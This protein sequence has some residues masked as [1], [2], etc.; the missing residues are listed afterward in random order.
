MSAPRTALF[1][2]LLVSLAL[3]TVATFEVLERVQAEPSD[4]SV[5]AQQEGVR[6]VAAIRGSPNPGDSDGDGFTD[7]VESGTPLCGNGLNEDDFDDA[8]ADDGCPGGPPQAGSFSEGQFTLGTNSL[9]NCQAGRPLGNIPST[10]WPL[11]IHGGDLILDSRNLIDIADLGALLAP[12]R[13]LDTSPG[14]ANYDRRYDLIPGPDPIVAG[15]WIDITDFGAFLAG[16]E[17]FPP[18]FGIGVR[19]LD[20]PAC[21]P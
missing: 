6:V 21:T 19:A 2:A 4:E 17:A 10:D 14:D 8:V 18:M 3:L 20:G 9:S 11:D 5:V 15:E 1:L 7:A 12:L 16:A 13:R